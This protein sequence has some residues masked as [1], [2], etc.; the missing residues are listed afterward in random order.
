MASFFHIHSAKREASSFLA[1]TIDY[2]NACAS[3]ASL[4]DL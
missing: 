2:I 3:Y 1:D 4:V